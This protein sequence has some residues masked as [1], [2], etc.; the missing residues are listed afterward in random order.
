M[1]TLCAFVTDNKQSHTH[2]WQQEGESSPARNA[3]EAAHTGQWGKDTDLRQVHV[4]RK[5]LPAVAASNQHRLAF[6]FHRPLE[7]GQ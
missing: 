5:G 6:P 7:E 4:R 1:I 3:K 2:V